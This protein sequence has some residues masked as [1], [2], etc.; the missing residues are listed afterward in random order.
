MSTSTTCCTC[1]DGSLRK[2]K[3]S[4]RDTFA[5]SGINGT[6]FRCSERQQIIDHIICS[7]IKDGGAELDYGTELGEFI[8]QRFP[9]HDF[10]RLNKIRHSWVTF[11]KVEEF[12]VTVAP[13]SLI[14]DGLETTMLRI[15]RTINVFF[16]RLLEQPL[17]RISDY[18]GET[19]GFYFAYVGFY[20]TWLML[21][22]I[23]GCLVFFF[24]VSGV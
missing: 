20:T 22:A 19:V 2:F 21:P 23:L 9:L 10:S 15:S 8:V 6:I 1:R 13:W 3:V 5:P 12:G 4:R 18:F 16:E 17:D 11:W 14:N 7:K 24:Q